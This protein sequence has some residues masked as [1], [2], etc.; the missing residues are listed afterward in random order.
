MNYSDYYSGGGGGGGGMAGGMFAPDYQGDTNIDAMP[1]GGGRPNPWEEIARKRRLAQQA[2]RGQYQMY[3]NQMRIPGQYQPQMQQMPQRFNRPRYGM[4]HQAPPNPWKY[5][6]NV[7]PGQQMPG[8]PGMG[9]GG[10]ALRQ[11]YGKLG[12]R[13]VKYQ[14]PPGRYQ[15]RGSYGGYQD[16]YAYR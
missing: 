6:W 16:P 7:G 3:P 5:N 1:W 12:Q 10:Y 2:G 9:G 4:P 13:N 11:R 8:Y 15:V 14:A